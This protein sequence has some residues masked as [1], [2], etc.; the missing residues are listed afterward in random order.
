MLTEQPTARPIPRGLVSSKFEFIIDLSKPYFRYNGIDY[1]ITNQL[2]KVHVF[3]K[4]SKNFK[5]KFNNFLKFYTLNPSRNTN[6]RDVFKYYNFIISGYN[7]SYTSNIVHVNYRIGYIDFILKSNKIVTVSE[8]KMPL[9]LEKLVIM[10]ER[11]VR[12]DII[13]CY[14]NLCLCSRR[15][16]IY[17]TQNIDIDL[18]EKRLLI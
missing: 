6:M 10:F 9:A 12:F 15:D 2:R 16:V 8:S 7:Y 18:L 4:S 11:K 1:P 17:S 14:V 3:L 5:A 13:M